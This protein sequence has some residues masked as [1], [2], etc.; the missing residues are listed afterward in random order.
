[1]KFSKYNKGRPFLVVTHKH[2]VPK[3]TPSH[4]KNFKE[5][6]M[7]QLG[8]NITIEDSIKPRHLAEASVIVDILKAELIKSRHQEPNDD[9]LKHYTTKYKK[10]ITEGISIWMQK[11]GMQIMPT[12]PSAKPKKAKKLELENTEEYGKHY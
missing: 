3:G 12:T 5:S 10:E 4:T 1:M 6:N 7:W 2:V 9:V 8:E 11:N